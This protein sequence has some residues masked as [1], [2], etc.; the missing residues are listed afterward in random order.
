MDYTPA[1][2]ATNFYGLPHTY[3]NMLQGPRQSVRLTWQLN[4]KQRPPWQ[5]TLANRGMSKQELTKITDDI[6]EMFRPVDTCS[7]CLLDIMTFFTCGILRICV[8]N[9]GK[10]FEK[11]IRIYNEALNNKHNA[12]GISFHMEIIGNVGYVMSLMAAD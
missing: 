8:P 7:S 11:K 10:L 2:V 12:Q 3:N 9:E 6:A 4:A 1:S 5:P